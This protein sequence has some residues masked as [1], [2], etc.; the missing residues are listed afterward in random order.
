MAIRSRYEEQFLQIVTLT[1]DQ[2]LQ[3]GDSRQALSVLQKGL[4]RDYFR[5]DLHRRAATAYSQLE[6]YADL[7][8]HYEK[9]CQTFEEE[10]DTFPT[11][12]TQQAFERWL[13]DDD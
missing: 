2:L 13:K 11:L 5:E 9:L 7:S 6:L 10:F 8:H 4:E 3:A 12:E 1:A